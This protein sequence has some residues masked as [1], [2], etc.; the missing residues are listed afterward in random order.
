MN[1]SFKNVALIGKYKTPAIAEPLLRLAEF[2]SE[3]G[4]VVAVDSLTAEHL[5][6]HPYRVLSLDKMDGEIDLAIV[7]GGRW[8][9][10][11]Y[12]PHLGTF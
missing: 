5:G 8:N 4:V 6:Q 1:L 9:D 12:C 2:L 7:M 11:E 3:K 10:A